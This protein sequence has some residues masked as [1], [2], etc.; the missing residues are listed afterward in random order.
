MSAHCFDIVF[1]VR[2]RITGKRLQLAVGKDKEKLHKE[3]AVLTCHL[4]A[5]I[6]LIDT[7]ERRACCRS[8]EDT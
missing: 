8:C 2:S 5:D 6:E 1:E 7:G 4:P 3:A